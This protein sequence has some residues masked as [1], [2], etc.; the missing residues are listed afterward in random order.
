M[1]CFF[2]A[3]SLASFFRLKPAPVDAAENSRQLLLR[4]VIPTRQR[5]RFW[6]RGGLADSLLKVWR[7]SS[8]KR[9]ADAVGERGMMLQSRRFSARRE[10]GAENVKAEDSPPSWLLTAQPALVLSPMAKVMG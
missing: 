4:S 9:K 10:I 2:S 7:R 3:S 5:Q 6:L 1:R 8:V